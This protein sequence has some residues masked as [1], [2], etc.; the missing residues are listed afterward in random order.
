VS[1]ILVVDDDATN[2]KLVAAL[3]S[4][5]GHVVI[6]AADGAEALQSARRRKPDLIISDILMPSMDGYEFV[7]QLR[8]DST[9]AQ[10]AVVFYTAN[11]RQQEAEALA[12]RCQVDRVISKPCEAG[13]F[14]RAVEGVL[15]AGARPHAVTPADFDIEHLRLLTDK[16]AQ[17]ANDLHSA[18]ARL[19]TL[20]DLNVQLIS[21]HEPQ[22]LFNRMCQGAYHLLA[23]RFCALAISEGKVSATCGLDSTLGDRPLDAEAGRLGSLLRVPRAFRMGARD[24]ENGDSGLPAEYGPIRSLL[25]APIA[26]AAHSYGWIC[27]GDKR[28]EEG[29]SA[30]DQ[31][32]LTILAAQVGRIH[33]NERLYKDVRNYAAELLTEMGERERAV[34]EL[35][36]SE[37]RFRQLAENIEDVFFIVI[38]DLSELIYISPACERVWGRS[39]ADLRAAPQSWA[40]SLH[41]EDREATLKQQRQIFEALPT[42]GQMEFRI[43]KPNGSVRWIQTRVSA[44]CGV[45]GQVI[46]AVGVS[47]DVTDRNLAETKVRHLNRVLAMLSGINS[48]IVRADERTVLLNEACRLTINPGMFGGAWCGL[49]DA[50]GAIGTVVTSG[51]FTDLEPQLHAHLTEADNPIARV[52]KSAASVICNDLRIDPS[53]GAWS[54]LLTQRGYAALVAL[55]LIIADKVIGCLSLISSER[56]IFDLDEMAL[57]KE[58][59]GDISFALD[60]IA[61]SEQLNYLAYYD[62]LTGVPN[63]SLFLDRLGQLVN[64]ATPGAASFAVIILDPERFSVFN[65]T[66][67]RTAAD[68][69]LR[70]MATRLVDCTGEGDLVGRVGA[71]QFAAALTG[72]R[73]AADVPRMV[74]ELWSKWLGE[75]Y[76]VAEQQIR[77]SAHAGVAVFPDDGQSAEDLLGNA[78]TALKRAK[79]SGKTFAAYTARLTEEVAER[80]R[81]EK[82]LRDALNKEEFVLHYQPKVDFSSRRLHGV[83]ALIRWNSPALGMIS[84]AKFVPILEESGL[85]V[86]VG[87]WVMQQAMLDRALWLERGLNAPRVSVNVST[88][89]LQ[90]DDFVR[91]LTHMLRTAG[92]DHGLDIEVT[93]SLLMQ[94]V[95]ENLAKLTA[96]RELGV[97]IA[98]DDFGTGFSSLSYLARL[99][100]HTLKIDRSF[101]SV[102]LDDPSAMTLV[103]TIISLARALKLETVAEGV[104][105]EEQAKILRLLHCDQMQGF[106]ISKPISFDAMT[107]YLSRG[108]SPP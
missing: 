49:V 10:T 64:R 91:R 31:R 63:R 57:L 6:E 95:Q 46:R 51:A 38:P 71:D 50:S 17:T 26:S 97:Q 19:R 13:D 4:F 82:N 41:P 30:E 103:S 75:P 87:A 14:I 9:L 108:H 78:E 52:M 5:E 27:V 11:Y 22:A 98:L 62:V 1:N 45:D 28:D 34:T 15:A 79:E 36:A 106:L 2:R 85:I 48:L 8:E 44:V 105:L 100:V 73:S 107:A 7:R 66:V 18:N 55:P 42:P 102:M 93:E 20:V 80:V 104:E 54:E 33:E 99:P 43:V 47:T 56:E 3:L 84:P 39:E 65:D 96:I 24:L 61:K 35:L 88:L 40:D 25:A 60:H 72:I 37:A 90:R 16:L 21:E 67:G 68:D 89:Q 32:L 29:F 69:L 101:I 53:A 23:A 74:E 83:E 77:L 70:K 59:A 58:M 76:P 81:L 12:I 86:E 92:A 94:D